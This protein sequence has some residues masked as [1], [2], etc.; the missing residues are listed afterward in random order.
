MFDVAQGGRFECRA[1][2]L[3]WSPNCCAATMSCA[4]LLEMPASNFGERSTNTRKMPKAAKT[5]TAM[6]D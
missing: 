4:S 3:A 1:T 6:S 2:Y 5:E